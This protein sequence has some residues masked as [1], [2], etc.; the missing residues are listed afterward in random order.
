MNI[1]AHETI[2][3]Q[4]EKRVVHYRLGHCIESLGYLLEQAIAHNTG[5][6]LQLSTR[7]KWLIKLRRILRKRGYPSRSLAAGC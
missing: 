3:G 6:S 1:I 5:Q 7:F 4:I 2:N